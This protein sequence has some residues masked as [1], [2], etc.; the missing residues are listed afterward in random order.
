MAYWWSLSE[1]L[2]SATLIT[3]R[4]RFLWALS[5]TTL[6]SPL[7]ATQDFPVQDM[8]IQSQILPHS[9][10]FRN[11][12]RSSCITFQ[13]R[14][15]RWVLQIRRSQRCVPEAQLW[16]WQALGVAP[17]LETSPFQTFWWFNITLIIFVYI[18]NAS[19]LQLCWVMLSVRYTA[20]T[21]PH[22]ND[23]VCSRSTM[24]G[25]THFSEKFYRKK[26]FSEP[27]VFGGR[28][29]K[30][31]NTLGKSSRQERKGHIWKIHRGTHS[32]FW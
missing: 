31:H 5:Q 9:S 17:L 23:D 29:V 12:C 32:I 21:L 30:K 22:P 15:D 14:P 3:P 16:V 20:L 8:T 11:W 18:H 13:G 26:L 24:N 10:T 6:L 7:P 2:C 19:N 28:R 27:N 25:F 1:P 4:C